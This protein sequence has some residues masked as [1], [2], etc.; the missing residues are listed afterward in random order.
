MLKFSRNGG[1][2]LAGG[3]RG[4]QSG[5]VVV[6]DVKTGKRIFE[7]GNE[8]DAV[9]AA[10]ISADQQLRSPW[11]GRA[12]WSASTPRRTASSSTR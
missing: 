2:L 8:P 3:G 4:G 9:L 11:A 12:R 10:D 1:L 6:W 5:K 7:V